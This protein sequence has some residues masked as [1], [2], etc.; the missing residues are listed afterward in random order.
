[1]RTTLTRL[2]V[3]I[4]LCVVVGGIGLAGG[5]TNPAQPK[6]SQQVKACS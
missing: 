6:P 4:Y 1:M 5:I 3:L 2:E